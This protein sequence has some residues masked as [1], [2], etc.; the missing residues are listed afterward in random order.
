MNKRAAKPPVVYRIID[1]A[2]GEPVGSYSRAYGE[3]YDFRSPQEAREANFH[4][5]FW[6]KGKYRIAKYKVTYE[7]LEDDVDG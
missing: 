2:T 6:D 3:E 4:G 7:L 5:M 1:Q